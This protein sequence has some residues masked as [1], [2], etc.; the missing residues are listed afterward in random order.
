MQY[1]RYMMGS[2]FFLISVLY[3]STAAWSQQG[4]TP[5]NSGTDVSSLIGL[6]LDGLFSRFGFPQSV[7]AVRGVE[8]WQDDVVFVY[9][10]QD[11]YVYK[12]RVW[13]IEVKAAYGIKLGDPVGMASQILGSGI[14][15]FTDYL[16]YP[17]PGRGWPLMLRINFDR[18]QS[19]SAIFIYRSDF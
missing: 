8:T 11:F 17:L 15:Y 1:T 10:D 5:P 2:S 9:E 7:H 19:V 13:Q 3:V 16:L 12:N 14:T 18:L 4:A 6:T